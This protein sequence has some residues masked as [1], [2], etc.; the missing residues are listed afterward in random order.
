M[1]FDEIPEKYLDDVAEYREKMIEMLAEFDEELMEKYLEEKELTEDDIRHAARNAV[2]HLCVTPVFCGSAFKNRGVRMLLDAV[3]D[4]L[5][6]PIDR[7]I[8]VGQ[9]INDAN[10]PLSRKPAVERPFSALAFK[11]TNDPYVGQQ[12]F[13]RVYSGELKSGTYVYNPLKDKRERA[14]RILRIHAKDREEVDRLIAGDIGALIGTKYTTT[15]DTLCDEKEPILLENIQYPETVID[16]KIDVQDKKDRDKL[17]IA[18]NRMSLEDPSLKIHYD[19]ETEETV[20]SG[21]GELHLEVVADRLQ[22]EHKVPVQVGEPAVA[23]RESIT[24]EVEHNYRYKKQTGG[25]GQFAHIVFRLEPNSGHGLEFVDHIKGGNI[26]REFIPSIQKS[27]LDTAEKG[28]V[29]GYPIVD[30]KFVLI[31]GSYHPVD[32]SEMAFKTCTF[33]ALKDVIKKAA[34]ELREPIMKIEVNT[35]DE[36]MGDV[37]GDINR[38]RGKIENMRRF[39]KGSQKLNGTVPLMQMFGYSNALRTI[40]SGRASYSMEFLRYAPLPQAIEE[41]VIADRKAKLEADRK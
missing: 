9:D 26:P 11:I 8:V 25:K 36:Y 13:V 20:I 22:S 1:V 18:L 23:F 10:I 37:I 35:P 24:K 32:S 21:M 39:R 41:K 15:G 17:S 33:L 4:Y 6:S 29:A 5:P 40:S 31:D 3:V 38:R 12:T 27:F 7:G 16:M 28:L 19:E 34:P 14:G 2:L 30:V